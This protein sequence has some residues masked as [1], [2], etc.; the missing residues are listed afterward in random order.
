[1]ILNQTGGKLMLFLSSPP[2]FGVGSVRK[3]DNAALYN[4]DR[5]D[6]VSWIYVTLCSCRE[7]NLR[8]PEDTFYKRFAA[9]CSRV[10]ICVDVFSFCQSFTDLASIIS[11]PK[12]TA[13]QVCMLHSLS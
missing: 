12:Y 7:P 4:T 11:L 13:G 3:R 6:P 2:S 1:M 5:S 9:E 8:N 10:H